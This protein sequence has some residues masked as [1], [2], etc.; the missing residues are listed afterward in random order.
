MTALCVII[1]LLILFVLA[2][3]IF[4]FRID[5]PYSSILTDSKGTTINAC[6]SNDD[7]WRMYTG[8]EEI[9][10]AI[11]KAIVYK[12]DR[13]F[14]YHFGI[15]PFSVA[16]AI[17]KNIVRGKRTSGASTITMQVARLLEPKE[18][19]Y[20]NKIIEMFRALQ[21][22]WH[23]SKD[24]ILQLYLN[25]VP[26]G[27]NIEGVKAASLIY[28]NKMP[29]HLS[30]GEI[31]VLSIIPNNPNMLRP[32]KDNS[33]LHQERNKWLNRYKKAKLFAEQDIEDAKEEALKSS[34]HEIPRYAPHIAQR[35]FN[36][37]PEKPVIHST[38]NFE[39]Q[40]KVE[41][42]VKEHINRWYFRNV[43]NAA[44]L[45]IDNKTGNV[46]AYAG[47]ADFYN[48]EDGGQVDG[49]RAIRSPGST[50][51]PLI[52]GLAIDHGLIT[53]KT[54]ISD[55]PVYFSGYEPE[56]YD[57]KYHGLV[58][59]EYALSNSLNVPAVK[60]LNE[61]NPKFVI[62]SLISAG[63]QQVKTDRKNL[64]L[65]VALGGCGVTLEE[66]TRLYYALSNKGELKELNFLYKDQIAGKQKK[67][68]RPMPVKLISEEAAY[69]ITEILTK[70]TRPDLPM[71]WQNSVNLPKVAWKTGTSY[72]RRDA[73]SIGY[74]KNYTIGV[75]AGNFSGEGVPE[76]SGSETASPLLFNIFN[77]LDYK[78]E[79]NWY[80]LPKGLESR[81]VCTVT[82]QVPAEFCNDLAIDYYIPGISSAKPCQ[83]LKEVFISPDSSVSYCTSCRP[84][85]GYIRALYPD[86]APEVIA[87][88][89]EYRIN[90][91]KVPPHNGECERIFAGS[92]PII[93][94]PLENAEY[95]V[96]ETDSM[97]IAL[98]CNAANDVEHVYWYINKHFYRQALPAEKLFFNATEGI[99][100]I[101][102]SDD[103][104]RNSDIH[105]QIKKIR[106]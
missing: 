17:V 4:P 48:E 91:K 20:G 72:G 95:Y 37:Y 90:Y 97:Q 6:L 94:S 16:R 65:S 11:K 62:K 78:S 2:D 83:H 101:S 31:A 93:T 21:L 105:I 73:W 88:F 89:D 12:E 29:D 49:I 32:G 40:L 102:C 38:I 55:V 71:E 5:I 58:S 14:Y 24:E 50:L 79:A 1:S 67:A 104:G 25:L 28:F 96:D 26:Y 10:P 22:E 42:I 54:V 75:W 33:L 92:A 35:L 39:T 7:K 44:V 3:H 43:K 47:S 15:N 13:F 59:V 98:S 23:F 52:Y 64:G 80:E 63:F 74:N 36:Q 70:V 57:G 45:V 46:I 66:M 53:P 41:S 100:E 99:T 87:Y 106:F 60:I 77:T 68:K 69:M 81:I 27:G 9:P 103:K 82:G 85:L 86:Y 18:R 61:L 51:K 84:Q 8:L 19:T 56:N 30:I 76:L 34:R